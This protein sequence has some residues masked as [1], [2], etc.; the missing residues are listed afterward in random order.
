MG[1]TD[2]LKVVAPY[3]YAYMLRMMIFLKTQI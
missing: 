1:A 3:L 2:L